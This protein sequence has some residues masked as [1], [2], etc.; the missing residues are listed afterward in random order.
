MS[1]PR[2]IRLMSAL[3][4]VGTFAAGTVTG[5]GIQRYFGRPPP[6]PHHPRGGP[7]MFGPL[8]LE[9]LDLSSEQQTKIRA[10]VEKH[11]P[12]LEKILKESF[13]KVRA[14]NDEVEKELRTVL[15]AEQQKKLDELKRH[16]PPPPPGGP[17]PGGFGP[18]GGPPPPPPPD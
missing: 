12:E 16:R 3:L 1:E 14:V 4:L 17:P 7:P 13:P 8:P 11:R 9:Q 2:N 6:P 5:A 18:P 15:T 10:I